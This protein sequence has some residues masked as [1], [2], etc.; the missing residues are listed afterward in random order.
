MRKQCI[1]FDLDG[2]LID[3]A[4]SILNSL[5]AALDENLVSPLF[6]PTHSLIGPPLQQIISEILP[7]QQH[8]HIPKVIES[9]K[10]HYDTYGYLSTTVYPG[11]QDLLEELIR[12]KI[13][14]YIGTNKR[15]TATS[16][17]LDHLGFTNYFKKVYTLD[18][19]PSIT[20]DKSVMLSKIKLILSRNE[21]G[22]FYVGDRIEDAEAAYNNGLQ[23][24]YAS[25]GYGDKIECIRNECI[26]K[27]PEDILSIV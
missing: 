21:S 10:R 3:S 23:F 13:N 6:E 19:F 15:I 14:L 4:P 5:K 27:S 17:I 2:T 26:L 25:W 24:L 1:I 22:V 8:V 11:I 12:K 20:Q 7:T 18:S 9:F 16:K